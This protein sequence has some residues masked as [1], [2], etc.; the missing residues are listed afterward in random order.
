[1]M[2]NKRLI[3]SMGES[4]KN[5]GYHVFFQWLNLLGTIGIVFV[6]GNLLQIVY[7]KDITPQQLVISVV[8]VIGLLLFRSFCA[9]K[10]S[11]SSYIASK[12]V[13]RKLRNEL[14]SKLL[15]LGSSYTQSV[16]S[17][18]VVQLSSEGI[19]QLESYFGL[20]LPQLFYSLL[21]PITLFVIIVPISF[22][23]AIILLCCVPLIPISIIVVQKIAKKLLSR[24]W[25]QYAKLGDH[26]LENLQ[27]LTTLKIYQADEDKH[28][29][30][31]LESENFRKVTMKVL[32]MQLN[33][34]IVMD[35][36]AY[37]A[38]AIGIGLACF[39]FIQKEINIAQA[40]IIIMLSAEFFLPLRQLGS[41][42]HIAMN[43]MASSDKI[44]KLFDAKE[45]EKGTKTIQTKEIEIEFE[46]VSFGYSEQPVLENCSFVINP[47]QMT[48][49]VGE[50]GS[51]K[52]TIASLLMKKI[53]GFNGKIKINGI[54]IQ[55]ISESNLMETVTL[56]SLNSYLFKGSVKTNLLMGNSNA[57]D[58]MC[59]DVLEQVALKEF[60][61]SENG[62][63]TIILEKGS[64]L[65]G[66]QQQRLALARALLHDS[67]VYIFDEATSNIDVESENKIIEVIHQL[68]CKKTVILITHR[69]LNVKDADQI[70]VLK[71]G[72][73]VENGNHNELVNQDAEYQT[74]WMTQHEIEN[75]IGVAK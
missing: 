45:K 22:E 48:A 27:G 24:Y 19:E 4:K 36:I 59:L 54:D 62:L 53:N 37:G 69:L 51:G 35:L 14:F 58:D 46:Q 29:A 40:F 32:S 8:L 13:K 72:K 52:S 56:V 3:Q 15:K 65:S 16:S 26:F 39:L 25:G 20:Y 9:I 47:K 41:Y 74:Y 44:F 18:E 31:N 38:S 49:I 43:G 70:L 1:M 61:E 33:S 23:V 21:A 57:T 42:F 68:A 12:D 71:N 5:I 2:I 7:V 11:D 67:A 10:I 55:D 30:M 75:F 34:I 63:D 73:I 50:S 64:N 6:L 66:G 28:K 60:V 17:S